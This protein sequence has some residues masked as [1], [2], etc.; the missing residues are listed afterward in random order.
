MVQIDQ[1]QQS[2]HTTLKACQSDC[3]AYSLEPTMHL[4]QHGQPG[5]AA[6]AE[7]RQIDQHVPTSGGQL[8]VQHIS[9][10]VD[11]SEVQVASD[12]DHR[13]P[14]VHRR[15]HDEE[16]SLHRTGGFWAVNDH[17]AGRSARRCDRVTL[18]LVAD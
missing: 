6:K 12:D 3:P 14:A 18:G 8:A 7:S 5:T 15:Y 10:N 13:V 1:A 17:Q 2:P 4:H 9:E 11:D 16:C